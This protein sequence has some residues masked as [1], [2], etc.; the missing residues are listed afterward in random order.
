MADTQRLLRRGDTYHY[1]RR[2]PLHLVDIIGKKFIRRSLGTDS[3]KEARR[4]RTVEDAR[5]ELMFRDAEK[6]IKPIA[7]RAG[8]SL[9]ALTV[10][11]RDTVE[12]MDRQTAERFALSPPADKQ[13]LADLVAEAEIDLSILTD[14]TDPRQEETVAWQAD[15][16]AHANSLDL[17]DA[18][19]L[20]QFAELVRRGLV[21]VARRRIGRLTNKN[22]KTFHDAVFD[23]ASKPTAPASMAKLDPD[24]VDGWAAER[25]PSQKFID[26]CRNEVRKFLAHS[27]PKT[28]GA[29]ARADVQAYKAAMIGDGQSPANIKTRL[30][31]LG[32]VLGWATEN[33]YLDANPAKGITIKVPKKSKDKRQPFDA[34]D[35]NAIFSGPVHTGGERPTRGRGEASY[36]LPLLALF[37]G[38]RLEEMAQ[39]RPHDVVQEAYADSDGQTRKSWFIKIVEVDGEHGTTVKTAGSERMVPIHSMLEELGFTAFVRNQQH[40]K[41]ARLFHLLKP[42]GYGRLG[43][44]WGEWWSRYMRGTIGITDERKVFHSFRHTFKDMA[45]HSGVTEGVAR[46]IMGH[47]GEDV[48]DDYGSGYSLFQLV[49]G[50]AKVKAVGVTLPPPPAV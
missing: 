12:E 7:G 34:E 42:G 13:S 47:S 32:T 28:V 16:I 2:V 40:A 25:K 17:T 30:S 50:M 48:A 4:L 15:R 43:N 26:S 14:L 9:E 19:L 8:V 35:L 27:G 36:W 21:E 41:H 44:K 29:I 22:G 46:Q 45:R 1:H 11:V 10:Y 31:R 37:T 6:G 5:T 49:E 18:S 38:A 39:L 23:P 33:G 3:L 20:A 24:I